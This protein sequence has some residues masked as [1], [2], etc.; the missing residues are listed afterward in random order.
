[1]EKKTAFVLL[2]LLI[3]GLVATG[4]Y[5]SRG[6]LGMGFGNSD[7]AK[8]AIKNNDYNRFIETLSSVDKEKVKE[9]MTEAKFNQLVERQKSQDA[10]NQALQN[11][12]Y[13]A[14]FSAIEGTPGADTLKEKITQE[15]FA[16]Y[17]EMHKSLENAR[18]IA[19]E[20]GLD[21][22]MHGGHFKGGMRGHF[23]GN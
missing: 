4:A 8:Q 1:M 22:A 2:A 17:V 9:F 19:K 23:E 15:N 3:L 12:D 6:K 10:I 5:A 16:K 13:N 7:A 11:S 14:W 18:A 20:L 21:E